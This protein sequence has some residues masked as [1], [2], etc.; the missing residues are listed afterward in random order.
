MHSIVIV[1]DHPLMRK[2]LA[3]F[4]AGSGRWLA[5]GSA[6]NLEEARALLSVP[7]TAQA[8]ILLLDIH[9]EQDWGLDI[10]P[11]IKQQKRKKSPAA[12]VYS[13]FD[14]YAHVSAA[15]SMGIRGYVTKKQNETEL[16]AALTVVLS[17]RIYIDSSAE[18]KLQSAAGAISLL[19]RRETDIFTL[20]KTGLS[21][22]QIADKLFIS[23]RTVENILSCIYDK[24]GIPS[25]LELQK[26]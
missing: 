14:D 19:T 13:A 23:R 3:G 11:W 1:E 16:E 5:L 18:L 20:V 22:Q 15:L 10:I 21:N 4:F 6:G 24:T 25:R 12:V 7:E 17:G 2:S 26:M 8:D 9:L